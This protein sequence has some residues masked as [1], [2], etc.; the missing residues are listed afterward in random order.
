MS[1]Q[2]SGARKFFAGAGVCAVAAVAAA[3]SYRHQQH[4]AVTHGQ[5]SF[6]AIIWPLCVDGLV[7]SCGIAISTDRASG[8]L[9]R[10]WAVVGFWLGVAVSVL[11][12]WLAT[13]GG[14]INH[15]VSAF[16]AVAFLIA[17][18]S[19]TGLPRV[20]RVRAK[21]P[22]AALA[23]VGEGALA[24]AP[25]ATVPDSAAAVSALR[26][27]MA[28]VA[29]DGGQTQTAPI[30][31]VALPVVSKA[32]R[33]RRMYADAATAGRKITHRELAEA[34]GS[35]LSHARRVHRAI[36]RDYAEAAA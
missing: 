22:A 4:L 2:V 13:E 27:V 7:A 24:P 21:A 9:P 11:T 16:P 14:L 33:M 10:I 18:E 6:L 23:E 25:Q 17:V 19:L 34:T 20:R 5:P 36:V 32:D 8:H 12:N 31:E 1:A 3:I 26:P 30:D 28:G 29:R 35:D 15:G